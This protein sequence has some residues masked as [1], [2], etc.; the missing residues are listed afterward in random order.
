MLSFSTQFNACAK[1]LLYLGRMKLSTPTLRAAVALLFIV[2]FTA[3]AF[4]QTN[5]TLDDFYADNES[6]ET[7]VNALYDQLTS[8]NA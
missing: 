8:D 3:Q 1:A 6:L 5:W 7:R 4:A 2:A